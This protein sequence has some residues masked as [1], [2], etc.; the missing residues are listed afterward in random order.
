LWIH[1]SFIFKSRILKESYERIF[2]ERVVILQKNWMK[3]HKKLN[4]TPVLIC[5]ANRQ[6]N[7]LKTILKVEKF[8]KRITFMWEP[9]GVRLPIVTALQRGYLLTIMC[10]Q[11]ENDLAHFHIEHRGL[12]A[13][14]KRKD[15]RADENA[16]RTCPRM[17]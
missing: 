2:L 17:Q 6:L 3:R 7:K 11:W 10:W 9:E 14:E 8:L 16:T 5:G 15:Q 12:F 4:K 1:E 13:G